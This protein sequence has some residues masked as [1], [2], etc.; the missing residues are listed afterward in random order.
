MS[1]KTKAL[2]V[3]TAALVAGSASMALAQSGGAGAATGSG[4]LSGS[5]SMSGS[6]SNPSTVNPSAAPSS[7]G[8]N[9][10]LNGGQAGINKPCGNTAST[11]GGGLTGTT[12]MASSTTPN[13][14]A[15]TAGASASGC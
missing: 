5:S 1:I 15:S 3:L 9:G 12:G 7:T 2:A 11:G 8:V 4:G 10:Q 13:A 6:P 14:S